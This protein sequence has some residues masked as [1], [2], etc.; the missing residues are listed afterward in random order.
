MFTYRVNESVVEHPEGVVI[1]NPI[2]VGEDTDSWSKSNDRLNTANW[3][4]YYG[5][6]PIIELDDLSFADIKRLHLKMI[7][8]FYMRPKYIIKRL[9]RLASWIELRMLVIGFLG[10]LGYVL[11]RAI[12]F[13]RKLAK[14]DHRIAAISVSQKA[15]KT[16]EV[17]AV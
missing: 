7:T 11:R 2:I 4:E 15:E 16:K 5:G 12:T 9:R 13:I 6:N 14:D 17:S 8:S 1:F 3:D 10:M